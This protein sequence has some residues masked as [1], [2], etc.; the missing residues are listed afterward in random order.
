MRKIAIVFGVLFSSSAFAQPSGILWQNGRVLT[1]PMMQRFDA[2]KLNLQ[3]LGKPGFAARLDAQGRIDAPVVGDVSEAKAN[4]TGQKV[5]DIAASAANAIPKSD[6]NAAQGVAGLD[7]NGYVTNPINTEGQL[8]SR[9]SQQFGVSPSIHVLPNDTGSQ[10]AT[11]TSKVPLVSHAYQ[12]N[13][14]GWE[15][16]N[17]FM[18]GGKQPFQNSSLAIYGAP[19]TYGN[20]GS[21]VDIEMTNSIWAWNRGGSGAFDAIAQFINAGN[22][23]PYYK[24]GE[25]FIDDTGATH[26]LLFDARGVTVKPELPQSWLDMWERFGSTSS[27]GMLVFTNLMAAQP[28]VISARPGFPQGKIPNLWSGYVTGVTNIQGATHLDMPA[29]WHSSDAWVGV[30]G[31]NKGSIPNSSIG[32]DHIFYSAY[33]KPLLVIG[34]YNQAFV[35]NTKCGLT[36]PFTNDYKTKIL[37]ND[38]PVSSCQGNELDVYV[39]GTKP[40]GFMH[41][42]GFTA[43]VE[44]P[45]PLLSPNSMAFDAQGNWPVAYQTGLGTDGYDFQGGVLDVGSRRGPSATVGATTEMAEVMQGSDAPTD[46]RSNMFG[47]RIT[48]RVDTLG[49]GGIA[50]IHYPDDN[51]IHV[52]A[53]IGGNQFG[54][55][56]NALGNYGIFRGETIY[57][58]AWDKEGVSLCGALNGYVNTENSCLSV[59]SGGQVRIMPNQT[60]SNVGLNVDPS[61]FN[62]GGGGSAAIAIGPVPS[63]V[64]TAYGI[65]LGASFGN[66]VED[67]HVGSRQIRRLDPD[68]TETLSGGLKVT[69]KTIFKGPVI[70]P[71]GTPDSSS[72]SCVR[73]QIEMDSHYTY[74]CVATNSWHRVSNGAAW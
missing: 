69:G 23:T 21:L 6:R 13:G 11:K 37:R 25:E 15:N 35:Q 63:N 34:T 7:E 39:P 52:G 57:N 33:S 16:P 64:S 18:L 26:T 47:I 65:F 42:Q 8:L 38:A 40:D 58:P 70:L 31:K 22:T 32:F 36:F 59:A 30:S 28:S 56:N 72:A 60:R 53:W 61:G 44:N 3:S 55:K 51:S 10:E 1:A 67:I 29:G 41:A 43:V 14:D 49:Y 68:G 9:S 54:V 12:W 71:F 48:Q 27:A 2:E 20:V 17:T 62:G 4:S 73:G 46:V 50:G 24:I 74:T 19:Y 66:T 45:T 5:S